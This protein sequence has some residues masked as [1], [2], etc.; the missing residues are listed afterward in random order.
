MPKTTVRYVMCDDGNTG[1]QPNEKETTK[2]QKKS[3][4]FDLFHQMLCD[5]CA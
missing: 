3:S 5:V 2:K 4:K 1:W